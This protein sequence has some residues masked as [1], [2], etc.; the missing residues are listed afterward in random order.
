MSVNPITDTEGGQILK[1]G[2]SA[3]E[4]RQFCERSANSFASVIEKYTF[5]VA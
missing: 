1:G 5:F 2:G 4:S 3:E